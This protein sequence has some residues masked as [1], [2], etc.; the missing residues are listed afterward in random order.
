MSSRYTVNSPAAGISVVGATPITVLG[1]L[2]AQAG[3]VG[4]SRLIELGVSFD[5]ITPTNRPVLVELMSWDNTL[6]AGAADSFQSGGASRAAAGSGITEFT[7]EPT[8]IDRIKAWRVRPDGGLVILQFP[9]GRETEQFRN[10]DGLVI[11]CSADETVLF[12]GYIEIE[13]G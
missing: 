2:N 11:R 6:G 4:G 7:T 5:G 3:G 12:D 10:T 1:W 13:E 9:L 8:V